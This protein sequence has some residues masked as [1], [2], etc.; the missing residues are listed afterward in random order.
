QAPPAPLRGAPSGALASLAPAGAIAGTHPRPEGV[1]AAQRRHLP[2]RRRLS[3][4]TPSSSVETLQ[5]PELV[6]WVERSEAHRRPRWVERS[7][8]HPTRR[9]RQYVSFGGAKK[10]LS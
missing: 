10:V 6:G 9:L 3:R 8:A 4:A 1:Q 2:P 7:E 5:I